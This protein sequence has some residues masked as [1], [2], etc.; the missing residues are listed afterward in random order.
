M[1]TITARRRRRARWTIARRAA[2]FAYR[3]QFP[4]MHNQIWESKP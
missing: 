2:D 1:S 3:F 4:G